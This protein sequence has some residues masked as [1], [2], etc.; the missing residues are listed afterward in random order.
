MNIEEEFEFLTTQAEFLSDKKERHLLL[1]LEELV[2]KYRK[3]VAIVFQYVFQI[4]E[5]AQRLLNRYHELCGATSGNDLT[6]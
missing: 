4:E 2:E 3:D 5:L 1:R 6:K